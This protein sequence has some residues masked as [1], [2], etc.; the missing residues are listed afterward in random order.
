MSQTA[1]PF[2]DLVRRLL[3]ERGLGLREFCRAV[4]VDPS[5]FSKVLAGKRSPPSEDAVLRRIALALELDPC[6]LI[7]SAG[8]IPAEWSRLWEELPLLKA[9]DRLCQGAD[10]LPAASSPAPAWSVQPAI[11]KPKRGETAPP[12]SRK[13][14]ETAPFSRVAGEPARPAGKIP[15]GDELL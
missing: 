4:D 2:A 5:F 7:V 9:V 15:F 6:E 14:G 3:R 8:R 12:F 10:P 11:R 1:P 13:A